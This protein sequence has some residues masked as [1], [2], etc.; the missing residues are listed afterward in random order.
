MNGFI[1]LKEAAAHWGLSERRVR[2]LCE[3]ERV[4][5]AIKFGRAW[6][7]PETAVRPDDKRIKTGQYVK[8]KVDN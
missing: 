7:I 1:T 8:E 6:A 2:V 4:D 5:G 3:E